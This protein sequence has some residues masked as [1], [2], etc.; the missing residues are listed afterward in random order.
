MI[1]KLYDP[2]VVKM[3]SR[4]DDLF[5]ST[6]GGYKTSRNKKCEYGAERPL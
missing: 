5:D 6:N 1:P 2:E 4:K 3:E